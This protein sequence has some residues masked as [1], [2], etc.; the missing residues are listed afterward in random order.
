MLYEDRLQNI[1]FKSFITQF[2]MMMPFIIVN[3][4]LVD[5]N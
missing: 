1:A 3:L 4:V 2:I 5:N